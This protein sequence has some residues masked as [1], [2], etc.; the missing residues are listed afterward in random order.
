MKSFPAHVARWFPAGRRTGLAALCSLALMLASGSV[1]TAG[2]AAET[3]PRTETPLTVTV[4]ILP[5][6]WFVDRIGG[7]LVTVRVLVGPGHSPATYEPTPRQMAALQGSALFFCAGVPFERGFVGRIADLNPGPRVVGS[8]PQGDTA[9]IHG[10][11]HTDHHHDGLDPHTW[12]DPRQAAVFADS[13]DFYLAR[14]LLEHADDIHERAAGLEKELADLDAELRRLLADHRGGVFFVFHP[15]FGH[16]AAAYGLT[17]VAIETG[18]HEPGARHLAQVIEQARQAGARAIVTQ[19][20]FS[21]KSA[22][23]VAREIGAELVVLDPLSGDY[24]ANL[25][26]IGQTLAR[27]CVAP[28]RERP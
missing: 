15:A 12:L 5:Q 8:Q 6:T 13:V 2:A 19:P 24:A 25:L 4:S 1:R 3:P 7:D 9:P 23:T 18:G 10:D 17:Q 28:A 20:Q 22:T 27:I 16:F 11:L 26:H 21:E 14:A